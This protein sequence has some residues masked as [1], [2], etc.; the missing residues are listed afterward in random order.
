MKNYEFDKMGG[1]WVDQ[2]RDITEKG[3]F[4]AHSG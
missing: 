2:A 3:E 4:V 1:I